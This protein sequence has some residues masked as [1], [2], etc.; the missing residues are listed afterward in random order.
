MGCCKEPDLE[1]TD[2]TDEYWYAVECSN[3]GWRYDLVYQTFYDANN[4]LKEL[5]GQNVTRYEQVVAPTKGE[6]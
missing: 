3:C 1:I 5:I 6:E 4:K 2:Y